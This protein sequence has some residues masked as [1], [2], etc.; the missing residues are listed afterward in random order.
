VS[1]QCQSSGRPYATSATAIRYPNPDLHPA[2]FCVLH[3][4]RLRDIPTCTSIHLH[5]P[6]F[7]GLASLHI[8][9]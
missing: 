7:V 1:H 9:V 6:L 4:M 8:S 3:L 2:L 5:L